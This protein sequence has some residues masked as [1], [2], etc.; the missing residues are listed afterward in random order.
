MSV[1]WKAN[2][3]GDLGTRLRGTNS[4]QKGKTWP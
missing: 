3:T 1:T 2:K 4:T